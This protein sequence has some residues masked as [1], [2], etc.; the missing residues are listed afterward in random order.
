MADFVKNF[1]YTAQMVSIIGHASMLP[2]VEHSG[3]GDHL[4]TPWKL[5]PD[6]LKFNVKGNIPYDKS[7]VE[8]QTKLLRYVLEQPYSRDMVCSMLGLQ[9]AVS[10]GLLFMFSNVN[11]ILEI[12]KRKVLVFQIRKRKFKHFC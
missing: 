11:R 7:L 1:R 5:D 10:T 12:R 9:K 4:I 3:Y 6:T 2:V 8:P